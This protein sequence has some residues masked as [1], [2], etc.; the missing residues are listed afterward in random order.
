MVIATNTIK[1]DPNV[2]IAYIQNEDSSV[3]SL[4]HESY[5]S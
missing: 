3:N 5:V 4:I 2:I 1:D